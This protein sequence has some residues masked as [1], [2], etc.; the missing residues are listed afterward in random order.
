MSGAQGAHGS[1]DALLKGTSA[2]T[3][4]LPYC[5][6]LLDLNWPRSSPQAK[7]LQWTGGQFIHI[8]P[9]ILCYQ[10]VLRVTF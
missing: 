10:S 7:S 3:S 9:L 2:A 5:G 1:F 4:P 8:I 6:L